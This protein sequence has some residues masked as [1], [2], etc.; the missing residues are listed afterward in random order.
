MALLILKNQYFSVFT[1]YNLLF[2][3]DR[4]WLTS[5]PQNPLFCATVLH[6]AG[7]MISFHPEYSYELFQLNR[8]HI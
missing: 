5:V 7:V 3:I 4:C 2:L 8:Y 1:A 6:S